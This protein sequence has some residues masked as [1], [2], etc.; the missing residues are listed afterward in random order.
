MKKLTG[1]V[2]RYRVP[3]IAVFAAVTLFFGYWIREIRI[4][5]DVTSYLP[6]E[7]PAVELYNR[8]DERF[9][10]NDLVMIAVKAPDIFTVQALRDI[11]ALT[12][13]FG[14]LTGV[15]SVTS[16][17]NVMDIRKGADGSIEI[18]KLIDADDLPATDGRLHALRNDVMGRERYRGSLVSMDATSTLI[19]CQLARGADRS[20]VVRA[21]QA[22]A[23][24]SGVQEKL[25]FGG[26]PVLVA[27]LST[28]MFHDLVLLIPIVLLLIILTL[29]VSF[30]TVRGV[31]VPLVSVIISTVWVLGLMG[32][33]R[34]PL[35]LVSDIIPA[36]L[37]AIGTAPCIHILSK[38]DE[39]VTLYGSSGE[40]SQAAFREVGIRV[41]LAALTI[42]L[43]FSSFIIGSYLTAIRDF[44]IFSSI[45]VCFSLIVSVVFV[46]ALLATLTVRPKRVHPEKT[47][48][49]RRAG[50]PP[51]ARAMSAWGDMVVR[52]RKAILIAGA[53]VLIAGAAGIPLIQ[54]K[55]DF[56][57]FLPPSNGVRLTENLLQNDFGG[58]RPLQIHF[59]GD[60]Q[61]P[62]VLKEM[63]R[64]ERFLEGQG[65]ARNPISVADL[66]AEMNDIMENRKTVP[67]SREKVANLMF[68]LEGQDLVTRM[69]SDDKSEAQVQAMTGSLGVT[70]LR[71]T[72]DSLDSY[73][74]SLDTKLVAVS[75]EELP[76]Q[77]RAIVLNY[78]VQ[79]GLEMLR[80]MAHKRMPDLAL[81]DSMFPETLASALRDAGRS[82]EN[83][84]ALLRVLSLFPKELQADQSFR[85]DVARELG[86]LSRDST[87]VPEAI[88][89]SLSAASGAVPQVIQFKVSWTG[90]PLISWHLDQS[91]IKSQAE[92][93]VIALIFIFLLLA[94]RLRSWIG[95]LIGLVPIL[96]AIVLMFGIMGFAGIPINVATVLVGAIALGI[97]IDYV[98]HFSIRFTTYYRGPETAAF[99][100]KRTMQTTGR[101]III[102]VMAVT[103]GFITLIFAH[104]LPL[105]QFG[106]LTAIAM[107]GS[108]LGALTLLPALI[109]LVPSAF[110]G[111]TPG[112]KSARTGI[113]PRKEITS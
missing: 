7:D 15:T 43:G 27:E 76:P 28:I 103:M 72:V 100:V 102:N 89:T 4:N 53:I 96:L 70:E 84:Q 71:R 50:A 112:K 45:G 21:M 95:G 59:S 52:H 110:A 40:K 108:G 109:L 83:D 20:A 106:I 26:V 77:D 75:L 12:E 90:M 30:G 24:S 54:Q 39:D 113:A 44:G 65:L 97:G 29:Y 101:A 99:A 85:E 58:S 64:L 8:M 57:F 56:A 80:W 88:Y 91:I 41:I 63:L 9:G 62:F 78:R 107:L 10:G 79:R 87:A 93:L 42:V 19:V 46:P 82:G 16:L 67:D 13:A 2:F 5:S 94:V 34:V 98:I 86:E 68:L 3:L 92:S 18:G 32:L 36:L 37:L 105:Q 1:L 48:R 47:A 35:T 66:I 55:A 38:Y 49:L 81:D 31:L 11:A 73:I 6:G 22:S 60:M 33:F 104:L 14:R 69:L 51:I 25:Y 74:R 17:S 111:R 61:N 23:R